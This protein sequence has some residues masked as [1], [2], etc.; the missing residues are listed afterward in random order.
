MTNHCAPRPRQCRGH[1]NNRAVFG[2]TW[3]SVCPTLRFSPNAWAKLLFMRDRADVEVGGFGVAP[4]DDLLF[5]HDFQLVRQ[6][7]APCYLTFE[8]TGVADYFD[9]QLDAGL[10]FPR[11]ARVWIHT[12]PGDSPRPTMTDERTFDREFGRPD[13]VVMF[14]LARGGRT[15]ARL[16]FNVGPGGSMIIPAAVDYTQPFAGSDEAAWQTEFDASVRCCDPLQPGSASAVRG[17][18]ENTALIGAETERWGDWQQQHLLG[19][20]HEEF[21]A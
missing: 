3:R 21:F 2:S 12:H 17:E 10:A 9:R 18:M 13:W 7:S 11:F 19:Q 14:I 16:R 15:Y 4:A 8:P 1:R 6:R 5:I 20:T